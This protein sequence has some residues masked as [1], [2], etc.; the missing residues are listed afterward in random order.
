M[1]E[2]FKRPSLV[3]HLKR[4]FGGDEKRTRQEIG[5]VLENKDIDYDTGKLFNEV[6]SGRGVGKSHASGKSQGELKNS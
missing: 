1:S 5:E 4:F 2:R 3:K 6:A